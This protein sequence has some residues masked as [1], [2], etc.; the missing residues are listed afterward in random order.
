MT[1]DMYVGTL[2]KEIYFIIQ[3]SITVNIYDECVL[4]TC[5]TCTYICMCSMYQ[6]K[7]IQLNLLYLVCTMVYIHVEGTSL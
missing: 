5:G 3:Q 1:Y 7:C 4:Y 6:Q 2:R